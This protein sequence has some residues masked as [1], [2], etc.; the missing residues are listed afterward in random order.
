MS[1]V[2]G[3]SERTVL[4]SITEVV[5]QKY[6]AV[7][8]SGLTNE[9]AGVQSVLEPFGYKPE[10]LAALPA[11]ANMALSCG[12]STATANDRRRAGAADG[13]DSRSQGSPSH[14]S[15]CGDPSGWL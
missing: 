15:G 11:G 3:S 8:G 7:A 10:G 4:P 5:R 6:G 9:S 13:G 1:E 2:F 12:N 14:E